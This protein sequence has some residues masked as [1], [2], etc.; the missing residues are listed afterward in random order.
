M[1]FN[2]TDQQNLQKVGAVKISAESL[3]LWISK[4]LLHIDYRRY[5][6]LH[7]IYGYIASSSHVNSMMFNLS[8]GTFSTYFVID[9]QLNGISVIT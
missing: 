2:T 3:A 9:Y 4:N 7:A 5:C 6:P 1:A 8:S